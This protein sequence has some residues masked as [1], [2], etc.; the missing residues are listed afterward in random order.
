MKKI[1]LII[2]TFIFA[3]NVYGCQIASEHSDYSSDNG[4]DVYSEQS[5]TVSEES[6]IEESQHVSTVAPEEIYEFLTSEYTVTSTRESFGTLYVC[7][8]YFVDGVVSGARLTTTLTDETAAEEYYEIIIDDYPDSSIDGL[9][10]THYMDNEGHLY[11]GYTLDKLKFM[12]EKTGYSFTVNFDEEAF[13]E[14]FYVSN[15]D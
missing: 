10:V 15:P 5:S 1:F 12:L 2:L 8:Y 9:T 6:S 11:Y 14:E 3:V 7:D 13:N 4:S